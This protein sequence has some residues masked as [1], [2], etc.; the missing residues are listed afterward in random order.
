MNIECWNKR[1]PGTLTSAIDNVGSRL[2]PN[3]HV[4]V[5]RETTP[6]HGDFQYIAE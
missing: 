4:T 5:G 2:N 6:S 3:H 1:S